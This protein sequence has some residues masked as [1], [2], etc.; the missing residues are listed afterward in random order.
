MFLNNQLD[1]YGRIIYKDGSYYVGELYRSRAHGQGQY[2][3][4]KGIIQKRG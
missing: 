3:D 2:Y 4:A 1:G